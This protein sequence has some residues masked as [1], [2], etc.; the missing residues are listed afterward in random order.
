MARRRQEDDMDEMEDGGGDDQHVALKKAGHSRTMS[1]V[2]HVGGKA[3]LYGAGG[4]VLLGGAASLFVGGATAV[5]LASN[6]VGWAV[7]GI[8]SLASMVIPGAGAAIL[9]SATGG[10]AAT[11]LAG[12]KGG[13]IVGGLLG[14]VIGVSG[15]SDAVDA[16]EDKIIHRYEQ[17]M[18]RQ[19][20]M[21]RLKEVQHGQMAAMRRQDMQ[22]RGANPNRALPQR[23]RGDEMAVT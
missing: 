21:A 13:A 12:A 6:P 4:A 10:I 23:G 15:A 14:S 1:M 3:L 8:A 17:A 5:A 18:A 7:T 22:M 2:K 16:E 20:R 19:E 11:F 9:G